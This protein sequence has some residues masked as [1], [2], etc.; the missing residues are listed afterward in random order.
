VPEVD[1]PLITIIGKPLD[2]HRRALLQLQY[3]LPQCIAKTDK[4][5]RRC[6]FVTT[7]LPG[8]YQTVTRVLRIQVQQKC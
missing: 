5:R 1:G 7:L 8:Y 2:E 3:R 4:S 6:L